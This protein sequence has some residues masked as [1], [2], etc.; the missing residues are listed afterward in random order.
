M[1]EL[2]NGNT[3]SLTIYYDAKLASLGDC[4]S[5]GTNSHGSYSALT[6]AAAK[7]FASGMKTTIGAIE[8]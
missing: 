8:V 3:G 7:G 5:F 2:Y 1:F 4:F 6:D